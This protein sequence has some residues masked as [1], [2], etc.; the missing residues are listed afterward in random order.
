MKL[1]E[2][3]NIVKKDIPLHYRREFSGLAI[4]IDGHDK[5]IKSPIRFTIEYRHTGHFDV[6]VNLLDSL[7]YPLIPTIRMLKD[8]IITLEKRGAL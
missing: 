6:K 8:H 3:T 4:F 7:N 5:K 2:I 1:I